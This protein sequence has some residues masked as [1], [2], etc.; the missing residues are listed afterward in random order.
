[1]KYTEDNIEGL[2]FKCG[3]DLYTV[4]KQYNTWY[5]RECGNNENYRQTTDDLLRNLNNGVWKVV[6]SPVAQYPIFN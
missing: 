2:V 5:A 1:M 3:K 4:N 6:E